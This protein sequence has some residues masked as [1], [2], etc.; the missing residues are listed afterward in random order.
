MKIATF[1]IAGTF[2][3]ASKA[4]ETPEIEV[5]LSPENSEETNNTLT[6]EELANN[7][8]TEEELEL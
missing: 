2:L 4:Q 3:L 6:E 7:T 5:D 1:L 8:L